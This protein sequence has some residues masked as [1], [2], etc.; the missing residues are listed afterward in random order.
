M[1]IGSVI[2]IILTFVWEL[3]KSWINIFTVS[4]TNWNTIWIIIPIWLSWFFAEF[5]QEKKGTSFGNAISNGVVPFWVGIDWL[6]EITMLLIEKKTN[7]TLILFGKY[8]LAVLV[9]IYGLM[10][11]IYGISGKSFIH[12]IGR[13]REVSYVLAMF[14]PL[15]YGYIAFNYMYILAIFFFFPLFYYVIELIDRITPEPKIYKADEEFE[16]P[17]TEE[18][19]FPTSTEM[20]ETGLSNFNEIKGEKF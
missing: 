15:V 10:I 13:I 17:K 16:K 18:P 2:L 7:F 9:L 8:A 5:F 1:S 4:F 12:Y 11:I 14:T 19:S 3:F 6:R 20:P